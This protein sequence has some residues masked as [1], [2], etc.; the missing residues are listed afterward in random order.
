MFVGIRQSTC[1]SR[2]LEA[3]HG[4]PSIVTAVA[5]FIA[6]T[7]WTATTAT[8]T[9]WT[10]TATTAAAT[11]IVVDAII[12]IVATT[13]VIID[14]NA[15]LVGHRFGICTPEKVTLREAFG[16]TSR[17]DET[18]IFASGILAVE[19]AIIIG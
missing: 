9:T 3:F 4:Q 10:A 19:I 15:L 18:V 5:A 7:T 2:R 6:T 11:V 8:T 17:I 14:G 12:V 1:R 13:V 16:R